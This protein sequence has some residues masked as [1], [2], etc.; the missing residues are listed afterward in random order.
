MTQILTFGKMRCLSSG[1]WQI[2]SIG[3]WQIFARAVPLFWGFRARALWRPL[4]TLWGVAVGVV[5]PY[6]LFALGL[7]GD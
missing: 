6:A 7:V 3:D 2:F 5:A 4:T 1:D